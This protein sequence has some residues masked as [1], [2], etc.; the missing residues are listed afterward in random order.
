MI[1]KF[2]GVYLVKNAYNFEIV[3][4][5]KIYDLKMKIRQLFKQKQEFG[6]K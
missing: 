1:L 3:Q 2:Q 5:I 6:S 4:M